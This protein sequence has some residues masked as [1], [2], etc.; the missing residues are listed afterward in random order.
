MVCFDAEDNPAVGDRRWFDAAAAMG[1][2]KRDRKRVEVARRK[3]EANT[4]AVVVFL[5]GGLR[6]ER[7]SV[8]GCGRAS[9]VDGGAKSSKRKTGAEGTANR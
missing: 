7:V 4:L 2:E 6:C 5:V 8:A 1:T 9:N 3:P